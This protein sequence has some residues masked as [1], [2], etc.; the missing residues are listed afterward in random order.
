MTKVK[1]PQT[2]E[3]AKVRAEAEAGVLTVGDESIP[4]PRHRWLEPPR[5][6]FSPAGAHRTHRIIRTH[7][8]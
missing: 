2:S 7:R 5:P 6:P 4:V 8:A 1:P 3:L